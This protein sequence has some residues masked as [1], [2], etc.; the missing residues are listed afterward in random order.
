M[1]DLAVNDYLKLT[2]RAQADLLGGDGRGRTG[3]GRRL[4]R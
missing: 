3:H 1:V 4:T 2:G